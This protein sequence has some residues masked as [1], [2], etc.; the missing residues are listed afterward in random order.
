[1]SETNKYEEVITTPPVEF[2]TKDAA[3]MVDSMLK[4][5]DKYGVTFELVSKGINYAVRLHGRWCD[6]YSCFAEEWVK[7]NEEP[8]TPAFAM[9]VLELIGTPERA[10]KQGNPYDRYAWEEHWRT[11]DVLPADPTDDPAFESANEAAITLLVE[12]GY[13]AGAGNDPV[14]FAQSYL[15]LAFLH[16]PALMVQLFPMPEEP[17]SNSSENVIEALKTVF[18]FFVPPKDK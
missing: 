1:M 16:C 9:A 10:N 2:Y 3:S 6:V 4:M 15:T 7:Y 12:A 13:Q 14:D 5:T 18:D 11:A 17:E 8:G